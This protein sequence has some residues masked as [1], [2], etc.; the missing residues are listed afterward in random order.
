MWGRRYRRHHWVTWV[1]RST[2]SSQ[3]RHFLNPLLLLRQI[4]S[5]LRHLEPR[6]HR[7]NPSREVGVRHN[8][9]ARRRHALLQFLLPDAQDRKSH[10]KVYRGW[11]GYFRLDTHRIFVS[12]VSLGGRFTSYWSN[13][14]IPGQHRSRF[15]SPVPWAAT[16]QHMKRH[17]RLGGYLI[18]GATAPA[19]A[20]AVPKQRN[21]QSICL[22]AAFGAGQGSVWF[23]SGRGGELLAKRRKNTG[24]TNQSANDWRRRVCLPV[25]R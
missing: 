17:R 16:A 24:G 25:C 4:W 2:L 19:T 1:S 18:G 9:E 10:V 6:M 14:V 8:L 5:P 11:R 21:R 15:H 7:Y 12:Y 20:I 13:K 22:A 3:C 23:V